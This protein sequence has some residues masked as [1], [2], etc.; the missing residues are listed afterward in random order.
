MKKAV[1]RDG[2]FVLFCFAQLELFAIDFHLNA[3]AKFQWS[4]F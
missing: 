4:L 3:L 2:L 1:L